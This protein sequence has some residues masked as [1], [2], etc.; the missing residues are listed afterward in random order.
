MR[1]LLLLLL[2]FFTW[3]DD[4]ENMYEGIFADYVFCNADCNLLCI[5]LLQLF[6]Q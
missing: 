4:R 6:T 1:I 3:S 5:E 2:S